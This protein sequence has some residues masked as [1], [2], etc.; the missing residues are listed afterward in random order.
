MLTKSSKTRLSTLYPLLLSF[1]PRP[2]FFSLQGS[3]T[4]KEKGNRE[5][6]R[7]SHWKGPEQNII[8]LTGQDQYTHEFTTALASSMKSAPNQA[9]HPDYTLPETSTVDDI[10]KR[11]SFLLKD[12]APQRSTT[13]QWMPPHS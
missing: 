6:V 5:I 1:L 13:L 12:V 4:I 9:L 10:L 8:F 11:E 2:S 7:I 3:G